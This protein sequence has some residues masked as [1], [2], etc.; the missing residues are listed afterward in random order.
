MRLRT[1]AVVLVA[2]VAGAG[3]GSSVSV[4]LPPDSAAPE[5]VLATYLGALVAGDCRTARA[6]STAQHIM[7]EG[8]W[9]DHRG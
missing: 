2:V 9:C 8:V 7:D 6:L 1:I 5:V 3:C 4:S